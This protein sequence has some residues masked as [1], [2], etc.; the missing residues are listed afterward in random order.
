MRDILR[1]TATRVDC[2]NTDPVGRWAGRFASGT[3]TGGSESARP[4]ALPSRPEHLTP[5]GGS[6]GQEEAKKGNKKILFRGNVD[7]FTFRIKTMGTA[8][9]DVDSVWPMDEIEEDDDP[10]TTPILE[11]TLTKVKPVAGGA[12]KWHVIGRDFSGTSKGWVATSGRRFKIFAKDYILLV[13]D[14]SGAVLHP[15]PLRYRPRQGHLHDL[16]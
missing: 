4:S 9:V 12:K 7:P 3:A 10:G 14:G 1:N 2:D 16:R 11:I 13:K 15:S 6:H 5:R 8:V